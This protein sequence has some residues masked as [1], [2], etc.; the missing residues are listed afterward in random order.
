LTSKPPWRSAA[1]TPR[2][3]PRR[4]RDG[5]RPRSHAAGSSPGRAETEGPRRGTEAQEGQGADRPAMAGTR[6]G[7]DGGARP[8]SRDNGKGATAAVTRCGCQRGRSFEGC[9][10][11]SRG[12]SR[13]TRKRVGRAGNAANPRIGSGMQQAR[14]R[15]GGGSRRG[16]EKPRGRNSRRGWPPRRRSRQQWR[17]EWT[18]KRDVDGG[19]RGGE[20]QRCA[21]PHRTNPTRGRKRAVPRASGHTGDEPSGLPGRKQQLWTG[22][23]AMEA[24]GPHLRMQVARAARSP[25][26]PAGDGQGE[27]GSREVPTTCDARCARETRT[28]VT[29]ILPASSKTP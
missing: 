28:R 11:T 22:A 24:A 17:R 18:P 16:G 23:K 27:G 1:A 25:R 2:L 12:R 14:E 4:R 8:R 21:L 7:P 19:A 15:S 5:P 13:S 29:P 6:T 10:R 20:A 3:R 9:E 26:T